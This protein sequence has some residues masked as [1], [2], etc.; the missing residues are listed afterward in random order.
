MEIIRQTSNYRKF[1]RRVQFNCADALYRHTNFLIVHFDH[2][3][4]IYAIIF[5]M[6]IIHFN[7]FWIIVI[8]YDTQLEDFLHT[9][10]I[11]LKQMNF[12][13]VAFFV[14]FHAM[15]MILRIQKSFLA[16]YK[17]IIISILYRYF[18]F[19]LFLFFILKLNISLRKIQCTQSER[20]NYLIKLSQ[21][22]LRI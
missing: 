19:Q 3:I 17:C 12:I 16:I 1:F 18:M 2:Y 7:N 14:I 11:N 5:I 22:G 9:I 20:I 21:L 15:H 8:F 6:M 10:V 13:F 4:L